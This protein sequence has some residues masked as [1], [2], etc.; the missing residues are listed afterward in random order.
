ML[1]Q[2]NVA[3]DAIASCRSMIGGHAIGFLPLHHA[4]S[5]VGALFSGYLLT[6]WG[7][8]CRSLKDIQKDMLEY[9][10]QN[11]S[12]VP[13]AIETIYKKIYIHPLFYFLGFIS[14]LTGLF[15]AFLF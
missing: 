10:P 5:W 6:E 8:I 3:S 4:F 14:I 7:F 15:K 9:H 12:A 2:N 13:L 11:F 1:T